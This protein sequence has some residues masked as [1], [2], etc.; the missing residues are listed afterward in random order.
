MGFIFPLLGLDWPLARYFLLLVPSGHFQDSHLGVEWIFVDCLSSI[1]SLLQAHFSLE[2][3]V[4][5]P[6]NTHVVQMNLCNSP[7]RGGACDPG[8]RQSARYILLVIMIKQLKG[9]SITVNSS[10]F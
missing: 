8:L 3:I 4:S 5:P 10:T 1:H 2:G 9:R 7:S 6:Y